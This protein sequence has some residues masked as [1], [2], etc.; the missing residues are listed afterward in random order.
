[1]APG[2]ENCACYYC[3]GGLNSYYSKLIHLAKLNLSFSLTSEK[4]FFKKLYPF[5]K[6]KTSLLF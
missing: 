6:R 2:I 4:K 3:F 5:L 1:M